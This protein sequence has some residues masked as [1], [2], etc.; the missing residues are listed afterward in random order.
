MRISTVCIRNAYKRIHF[1]KEETQ[2][3]EE[4]RV[5][6]LDG[7]TIELQPGEC[8]TEETL[9]ELTGGKGDE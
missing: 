6:I 3:A 7:E 4:K 8:I 9:A 2:M 5:I 1:F